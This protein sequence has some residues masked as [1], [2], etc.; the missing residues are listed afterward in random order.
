MKKLF[1]LTLG[2][3]AAYG[4]SYAQAP[5]KVTNPP[6]SIESSI[7]TRGATFLTIVNK[8]FQ[9]VP[10]LG[11]YAI[12]DIIG[13]W[14]G[15]PDDFYLVGTLTYQVAKNFNVT[16]GFH[17][18]E[19]V[20]IR[21]TVGLLYTYG[22]K[23]LFVLINPKYNIDNRS[24]LEV[25]G[26]VEYQPSITEKVRLYSRIQ[27]DYNRTSKDN[28]HARSSYNFRL[29]V[30]YKEFTIGLATNLEYYGA[31]EVGY[32]SYGGFIGVKLY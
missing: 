5:L 3:V 26:L 13:A 7:G 21:P 31:A 4:H 22:K 9:S 20:N 6:V 14:D 28:T 18:A 1:L 2:G 16:A 23:D 10:K 27:S 15:T 11:V 25:F 32:P 17:I 8:K 29:G 30:G 24:D 12:N 19:K